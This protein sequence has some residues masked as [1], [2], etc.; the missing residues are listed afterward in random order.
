MP[1]KANMAVVLDTVAR[2]TWGIGIPPE[3]AQTLDL[4]NGRPTHSRFIG[5]ER[6]ADGGI[7]MFSTQEGAFWELKADLTGFRAPETYGFWQMDLR[8]RGGLLYETRDGIW[9]AAPSAEGHLLEDVGERIYVTVV[10][11]K[12]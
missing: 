6:L 10:K 3:T 9:I 5:A 4:K 7:R 8:G 11:E 12:G 2:K 1:R